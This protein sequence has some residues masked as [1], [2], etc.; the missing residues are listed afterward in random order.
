MRLRDRRASTL[1][2]NSECLGFVQLELLSTGKARI[3]TTSP[4]EFQN[5]GIPNTVGT[6]FLKAPLIEQPE[7]VMKSLTVL[8]DTPALLL[9]LQKRNRGTLPNSGDFLERP[10]KSTLN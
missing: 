2:A 6:L 3:L 7:P 4:E 10:C 1:R 5:C 9:L 8:G